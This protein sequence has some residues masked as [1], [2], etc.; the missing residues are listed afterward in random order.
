MA[1]DPSSGTRELPTGAG[2]PRAVAAAPG[3]PAA[4]EVGL[5]ALALG[6]IGVVY[7][8]IGTSPL[9]A[10][11]ECFH[12][13]HGVALSEA[14][15]LGVL[16]LVVW[17]LVLV[18]CVKY[19]TF[20]MRADNEGEGGILALLALQRDSQSARWRR[21]APLL[22]L[23]GAGLLYGDGAITP[24]ISILSAIE[25]IEIATPA[26]RDAVVPIT[27]VLLIGLFSVQRFG[28]G[29]IGSVFGWV[30]LAWFVAIGTAGAI[31]ALRQPGVLA[32]VSPLHAIRF[33]AEH[34]VTAFLLLASVVLV[35]TGSEALYTDMG[36]FGA[37]PIRT[38]WYAVVMPALVLNYLGQGAVLL[39]GGVAVTNPFY[40]LA[41]GLWL[42]PMLVLATLAAIIAS[43]ALIS[44]AYSLTRSAIQLGFFPR[45]RIVHTSGETEGQ[46]YV[47]EINWF[48]LLVCLALVLGFGSSSRLAAAY[49]IAVTG[50]MTMTSIL[51]FGL[52][53]GVWGWS[54]PAAASLASGFL[55]VDAAF[56][57][58]NLTK[59][60][61]GGWVPLVLGAVLVVVM[62][63]WRQGREDLARY[64]IAGTMPV[65][66]FLA[67]VRSHGLPRVPGTAVFMTSNPHGI[68]PVLLH[69]VKH[70]KMLHEQVV[71][72]SI[73]TEQ[74]PAV[75]FGR[76]F[77]VEEVGDGFWRVQAR[78]GFMQTPHV[79]RLLAVCLAEGLAVDLDDTSYFLGRETLLTG[80]P[81]RM[82][83]WRK[84]L[85]AY[86]SRNSRPAT[87]FFGLPPNRVV[88]LGAQIEI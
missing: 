28:T 69:H 66:V 37:R 39:E 42:Y 9:Y 7:G 31:A 1:S 56:L 47:P 32:A 12:G 41:P 19:L 16:S 55:L 57:G 86:L 30:M 46:I 74:V 33:L 87:Q 43:Q 67:D 5:P 59:V 36:H 54:L 40:A 34:G 21:I 79:P 61:H 2:P 14:N 25:G 24:A 26:L 60:E 11:R 63:T 71:L 3:A 78:Y 58:A 82:A 73:T 80:G 35:V 10:L 38:A 64:F 45:M 15:V 23:I 75:P 22:A 13:S 18:V 88:E 68:P 65:D 20:I 81:S 77:E 70:N 53:R 49:G 72:L 27:V 83:R 51:F 50:T 52:A 44:G 29:R 8:D 84:A 17:A 4:P 62:T 6:A 48:L 85:F 76:N